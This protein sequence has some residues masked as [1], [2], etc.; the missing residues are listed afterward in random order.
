MGQW[1]SSLTPTSYFYD[2]SV[3]ELVD[4]FERIE[5][6]ENKTNRDYKLIGEVKNAKTGA[7][8]IRFQQYP[9]DSYISR[10]RYNPEYNGRKLTISNFVDIYKLQLSIGKTIS[11]HGVVGIYAYEHVI[12]VKLVKGEKCKKCNE[13]VCIED[14]DADPTFQEELKEA[15]RAK[16]YRMN[17]W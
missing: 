15:T 11:K 9:F 12:L 1:I 8:N 6:L 2:Y 16:N 14:C 13:Y 4:K 3:S 7:S 17:R 10:Y 5:K